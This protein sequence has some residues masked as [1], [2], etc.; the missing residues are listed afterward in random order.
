MTLY[1]HIF[2]HWSQKDSEKGISK[3][4]LAENNREAYNI[5]YGFKGIISD[6]MTVDKIED[7]EEDTEVYEIDGKEYDNTLTAEEA[8]QIIA[9]KGG[10]LNFDDVESLN[11]FQDLYYGMRLDGWEVVQENILDNE[12]RILKRLKIIED[13]D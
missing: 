12:I 11:C 6:C 2:Q 9:D 7:S 13:I 5:V 8:R 1:K 10:E 3:Y 4:F